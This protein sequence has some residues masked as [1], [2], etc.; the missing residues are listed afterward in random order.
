MKPA[1]TV[2]GATA[3]RTELDEETFVLELD[4]TFS[5]DDDLAIEEDDKAELDFGV[6]LEDDNAGTTDSHS[7]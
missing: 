7:P 5:L 1:T 3:L 4:L 6:M 2:E